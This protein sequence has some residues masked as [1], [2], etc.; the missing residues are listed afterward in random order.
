MIKKAYLCKKCQV[1]NAVDYSFLNLANRITLDVKNH[2]RRDNTEKGF[3]L[4]YPK[5]DFP[6]LYDQIVSG[7][8]PTTFSGSLSIQKAEDELELDLN[9]QLSKGWNSDARYY[10]NL[11]A[12]DGY[13]HVPISLIKN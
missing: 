12:K 4:S 1:K 7:F 5:S 10:L 6:T 2:P 8:I 3:I 13:I 11:E 9:R